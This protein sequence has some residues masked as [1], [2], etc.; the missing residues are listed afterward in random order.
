M[1]RNGQIT[2]WSVLYSTNLFRIERSCC[3]PLI[4]NNTALVIPIQSR[5]YKSHYS[6]TEHY[7]SSTFNETW[8]P[9]SR[10]GGIMVCE[11]VFWGGVGGGVGRG[12]EGTWDFKRLWRVGI[13]QQEHFGIQIMI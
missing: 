1:I 6:I 5:K 4:R 10:G 13:I 3:L 12:G 2:S 7:R 11:C 9:S 8:L